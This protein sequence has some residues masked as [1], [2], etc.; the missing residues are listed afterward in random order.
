M[1]SRKKTK[2]TIHDI[3]K[4]LNTTASTVSR[5][6]QDHP[7][8]S[9]GMKKAVLDLAEKLNYHPN[10]IAS[11]LRKGHGNTIGIVIPRIDRNFFSSVIGGIEDVA[12]E[13]GYNVLISQSYESEEKEKNIVETLINGKVDGLLVS[14]ASGTTNISHFEQT[15]EKGVPLI[16]F[17]RTA[18]GLDVSKVEIDDVLGAYMAV[19][20]LISQGCRRIAHFSGPLNVSIYANRFKGYIDA[21]KEHGIPYDERLHITGTITR[22][23]GAEGAEELLKLEHRPDALFSASD[24]SALGAISVLKEKNIRIPEDIA[25]VGFANEPYAAIITPSLSSVD[26]HSREIGQAAAKLFFEEIERRNTPY[27]AKR[28]ILTP[29]LIIRDS[30]QKK[31]QP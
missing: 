13:A 19:S 10:F 8:I 11:S 3:A 9:A 20:H 30:S 31:S 24:F 27:V 23:K 18:P 1:N 29:D 12:S 16:F 28:I 2:V 5:A 14:L 26:Q 22:D 25:V 7:R 6:L 21:L 4:Q 17:D 15:I